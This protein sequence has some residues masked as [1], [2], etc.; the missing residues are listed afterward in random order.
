[1]SLNA[2]N[3]NSNSFSN[4]EWLPALLFAF[5]ILLISLVMLYF[6]SL[7][8][9]VLIEFLPKPNDGVAAAAVAQLFFYVV[10][11]VLTFLQWAILDRIRRVFA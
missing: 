8:S 11:V 10:P 3:N 6:N 5:W 1:M 2:R 4:A 9:F 7:L